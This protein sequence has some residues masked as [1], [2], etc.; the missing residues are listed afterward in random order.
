[1]VVKSYEV[2]VMSLPNSTNI[3]HRSLGE[4]GFN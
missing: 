2:R 3:V 1:L 4:G